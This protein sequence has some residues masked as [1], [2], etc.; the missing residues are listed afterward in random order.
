MVSG[1][2]SSEFV[3][4]AFDPVPLDVSGAKT[5]QAKKS[6]TKTSTAKS[7]AKTSAAKKTSTAKKTARPR[8]KAA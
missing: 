8:K 2:Q 3:L 7:P 1:V 4:R 5:D 6:T